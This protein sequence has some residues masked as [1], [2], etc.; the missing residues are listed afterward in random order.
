MFIPQCIEQAESVN[1]AQGGAS[2]PTVIAH[3][4][5]PLG[6]EATLSTSMKFTTHPVI[7]VVIGIGIGMLSTIAIRKAA[8]ENMIQSCYKKVDHQLILTSDFLGDTYFCVDVKY[9]Q[10]N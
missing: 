4:I 1:A 10:Y 3:H 9:L 6:K 8:N 2:P 7:A 5:F